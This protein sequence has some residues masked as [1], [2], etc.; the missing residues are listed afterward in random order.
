MPVSLSKFGLKSALE[1]F[2]VQFPNVYLHF[3]GEE[4]RFEQHQEFTAYCCANELITNSIKHSGAENI[5][6][7]LVQSKKYLSLTVQDDGCGFDEKTIDKGMGLENVCN[8]V[9]ASSGKIDIASS[10]GKGTETVIEFRI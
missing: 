10:S 6:V 3:F 8:R 5:H 7:Q 9:T 2:T 4:G 1:D